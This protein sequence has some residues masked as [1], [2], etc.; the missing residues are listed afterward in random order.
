MGRGGSHLLTLNFSNF[1]ISYLIQYLSYV[2]NV[3]GFQLLLTC[4]VLNSRRFETILNFNYHLKN[5]WPTKQH[6][7]LKVSCKT[8]AKSLS[9]GDVQLAIL[10]IYIS[11]I[12]YDSATVKTVSFHRGWITILSA[13]HLYGFL[14]SPSSLFA[15]N[16]KPP[17]SVAWKPK[18][19][20]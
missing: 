1:K 4:S 11:R 3:F 13:F 7:I 16:F 10:C 19:A 8:V 14:L 9:G 15:L 17:L 5:I 12:V 2:H 20:P 6:L 18:N